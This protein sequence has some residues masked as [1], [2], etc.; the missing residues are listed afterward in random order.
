MIYL[1][2]YESYSLID[3]EDIFIELKDHGKCLIEVLQTG[4]PFFKALKSGIEVVQGGYWF[5]TVG[6]ERIED[7]QQITLVNIRMRKTEISYEDI[8]EY[9]ERAVRYMTDEGW[10]YL[11]EPVYDKCPG[12]A[13]VLN[14]INFIDGIFLTSFHI[15]FFK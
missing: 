9:V 15:K 13:Y 12:V 14:D 1:K 5:S 4:G 7:I 10:N 8:R 3:L 6:Q 11:L 2:T